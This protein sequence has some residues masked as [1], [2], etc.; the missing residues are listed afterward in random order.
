[1]NAQPSR[2]D[3][4][5][6]VPVRYLEPDSVF[7]LPEMVYVPYWREADQVALWDI[8]CPSEENAQVLLQPF[9]ESLAGSKIQATEEVTSAWIQQHA[10]VRRG[11]DDEGIPF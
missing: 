6:F 3:G 4:P 7:R 5:C 8:Q 1:M 9:R 11:T 10:D 2:Y